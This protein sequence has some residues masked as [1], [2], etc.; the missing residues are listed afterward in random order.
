VFG[1]PT[2]FAVTLVVALAALAML[3]WVVRD[4]RHIKPVAIEEVVNMS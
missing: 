1:Y 4:P 3:R 2:L